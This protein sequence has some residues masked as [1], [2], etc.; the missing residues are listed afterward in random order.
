MFIVYKPVLLYCHI[1]QTV[2]TFQILLMGMCS[3]LEIHLDPQQPTLVMVALFLWDLVEDCVRTME[4]GLDQH[5]FVEN[6]VRKYIERGG[7]GER[8]REGRK[9]G[10]ERLKGGR[11]RIF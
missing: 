10:S 7:R 3:C 11:E 9:G 1:Q 4:C 5:Q 8:G 6:H 2:P